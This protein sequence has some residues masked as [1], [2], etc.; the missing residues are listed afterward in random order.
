M[1]GVVPKLAG[2]QALVEAQ[3]RIETPAAL[4]AY[5]LL[6]EL[7]GSMAVG[8]PSPLRTSGQLAAA[9]GAVTMP[10]KALAPKPPS[11]VAAVDLDW[12]RDSTSASEGRLGLRF[13][14]W[15][16]S[17]LEQTELVSADLVGGAPE[18][19]VVSGRRGAGGCRWPR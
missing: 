15:V 1:A 11:M 17:A 16:A 12:A 14:K 9:V 4:L 7:V 13:W 18:A 10:A 6:M 2:V 3:W 8:P 5:Q 19:A